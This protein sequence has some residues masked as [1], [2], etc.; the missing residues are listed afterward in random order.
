MDMVNGLS[1]RDSSIHIGFSKKIGMTMGMS[2][3]AP[4]NPPAIS[5]V[6]RFNK[7]SPENVIILLMSMVITLAKRKMMI[8]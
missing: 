2:M 7:D 5:P 1:N 8:L 6:N 4:F 3:S